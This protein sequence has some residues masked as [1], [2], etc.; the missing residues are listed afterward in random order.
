M[1]V[2]VG[3][4]WGQIVIKTSDLSPVVIAG[5]CEVL[6]V[7]FAGDIINVGDK[8]EGYEL[9]LALAIAKDAGADV[10][11][12]NEQ[13]S[14]QLFMARTVLYH[15]LKGDNG[16]DG[17][18]ALVIRGGQTCVA[19]YAD[20]TVFV[21]RAAEVEYLLQGKTILSHTVVNNVGYALIE[22]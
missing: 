10:R 21:G 5:M 15:G 19:H 7:P 1:K 9:F 6:G 13:D 18:Q 22:A 16:Y 11:I 4:L 3:A 12:K 17:L 8:G 2:T 14:H 20:K